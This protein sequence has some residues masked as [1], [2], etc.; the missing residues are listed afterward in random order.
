[1][2]Q[3]TSLCPK[4]GAPV[5]KLTSPQGIE[6]LVDDDGEVAAVFGRARVHARSCKP[7]KEAQR[8]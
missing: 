6:I 8:A 5:R 3:Q 7:V 4:C 2:A 1:M